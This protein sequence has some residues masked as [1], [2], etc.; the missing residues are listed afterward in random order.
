MMS[1]YQLT[2]RNWFREEF[3]LIVLS[4]VLAIVSIW[5]LSK[6]SEMHEA[7]AYT[8]GTFL[9]IAVV[10]VLTKETPLRERLVRS[11]SRHG[12]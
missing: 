7:H 9:M 11:F 3:N 10:G 2:L 1:K 4:L 5:S 6:E 8:L 12:L